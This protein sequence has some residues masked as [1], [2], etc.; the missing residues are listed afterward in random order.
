VWP[1]VTAAPTQ[2]DLRTGFRFKS[3]QKMLAQFPGPWGL[4]RL[5]QAADDQNGGLFTF[6]SVMFANSHTPLQDSKGSPATI[7][8]RIDS[9]A[10]N[11][12]GRSYFSKLRCEGWWAVQLAHAQP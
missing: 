8:I 11:I 1:P 9:A 6:R 12:F 2:L 5:L 10:S 3:G 4:F 7:Q